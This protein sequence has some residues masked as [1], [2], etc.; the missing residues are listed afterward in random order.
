MKPFAEAIGKEPLYFDGAMGTMLQR[1]GLKPGEAPETWNIMRPEI[2]QDVHREYI[3]SGC[4]IIKTN[5][6]GAN[7]LA[8]GEKVA[9]ELVE[10]GVHLAREVV[11][12][13]GYVALDIGPTGK[14]LAPMGSLPFEEAVGAFAAVVRAGCAAGADL[15]LIETMSDPYEARAALLA[16]KENCDL[17]VILT[18]TFDQKGKLF[19]GGDVSVA[20][21]VAES[22]GAD[23]VGL[24][25]GF[26]PEQ[27]R[28]LAEEFL[29]FSSLP[30][31]VNPNAG[32]PIMTEDGLSYDLT[33]EAFAEIMAELLELG[34]SAAGGCCG[35][36]PRHLKAM[37]KRSAAWRP[38]PVSDKEITYVTSY[39]KTVRIGGEPVIIG[40]RIN[41]TG[42]PA[43]RKALTEGDMAFV[44][45][46]GL[47]QA[48]HGAHVLDVNVGV[49][50]IDEAGTMC[51]TVQELQA[52]CDLPLQID[53]SDFE[54]L[55]RALRLYNGRPLLNSVNGKRDSLEQILPLAKKY[56]AVVVALTLDENGIPDTVE[57]RL[58]VARKILRTAEDFG[59]PKKQIVFD[60]LTMTVSTGAQNARITLETVRVLRREWGMQTI[61]GVSN[62]SFG[63]P[64]R[65][66]LNSA[67]F[68]MALENGLSAGIIN[69]MS[70][71]MMDAYRSFCALNA[72]DTG[73]LAY[74]GFCSEI[75]TQTESVTVEKREPATR[76]ADT[77]EDI[78]ENGNLTEKLHR[79]VVSGLKQQASQTAALM[80]ETVPVLQ[81]IQD[82]LIPALNKVGEE[83]ESNRIF[84]PQLMM[85]AEAAKEAF[86]VLKPS[87]GNSGNQKHAGDKIA[88]ATVQGD[89]HDIGKNIVKLLL[90]SYGFEVLDLGKD[91]A[92]ETVA[93]AAANEKLKLVGLSALMTTTVDSMERTIKILREKV[94]AC[95]VMVGG[96]VLT[97]EY[98]KAIGADFYSPDAMGSVKYAEAVFSNQ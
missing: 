41:P 98:A 67:F 32:L 23:G 40:E 35:T 48:S 47:G 18:F 13:R 69:P 86:D 20:I 72:D 28:P 94:P 54:T 25:C 19:T 59:I 50:G 36:T 62:V 30:V 16:V 17:P 1:R 27:M 21:G 89:I 70:M 44:L 5:T 42:K 2:V 56:G 57:G 15:V 39:A 34:V 87:L 79:A 76:P 82:C 96:A 93:E 52:V 66:R 80:A 38:R 55:E 91:V 92:P 84:L 63:L 58:E 85:S 73:C 7:P 81:I 8:Y 90:E 78:S 46:E 33:P 65:E 53:S 37:I 45:N 3:N 95:K 64:Q 6:F 71:R 10:A 11:R 22:L 97:E 75:G 60:P 83:F 43:F 61:L 14:L 51:R 31:V 74:I 29:H 77:L 68:T 4:S 88:L 24:N 12:D 49:P 9:S 26:G